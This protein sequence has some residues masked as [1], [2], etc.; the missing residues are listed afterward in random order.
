MIACLSYAAKTSATTLI[1]VQCSALCR[2]MKLSPKHSI[3]TRSTL[4]MPATYDCK[5]LS[6]LLL[7]CASFIILF[8]LFCR[9]EDADRLRS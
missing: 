1:N 4:L 5:K 8:D 9:T 3:W 2:T 7:L 6:L